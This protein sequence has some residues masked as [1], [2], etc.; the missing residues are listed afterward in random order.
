MCPEVNYV[1]THFIYAKYLN[2]PRMWYGVKGF[3]IIY[4]AH[5]YI[6]ESFSGLFRDDINHQKFFTG[7]GFFL[8]VILFLGKNFV[9]TDV[10]ANFEPDHGGKD[11]VD[12][13]QK[14][15]RPII[16]WLS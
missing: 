13:W 10:S 1:W 15:D 12:R 14:R 6:F 5:R 4:P 7:S 2:K 11:L 3:L 9:A 8:A 16:F